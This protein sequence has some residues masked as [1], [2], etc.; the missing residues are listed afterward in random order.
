QKTSST[1][2]S[3]DQLESEF[4]AAFHNGDRLAA[5]K[6]MGE[7]REAIREKYLPQRLAMSFKGADADKSADV[8][9]A[10]KYSGDIEL[11]VRKDGFVNDIA[12]IYASMDEARFAKVGSAQNAIRDGYSYCKA[13]NYTDCLSSFERARDQFK[14]AGDEPEAK[15]AEYFVGYAQANTENHAA[16]L[17]TITGVAD[18]ARSHGYRWLEMTATHWVGGCL[19]ALKKHTEALAT[20]ERALAMAREANDPHA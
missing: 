1:D 13:N 5:E 11:S 9:N 10:L 2:R 12:G 15:L 6:L 7:S 8:L 14:M 17:T 4:L 19:V 20:Y 16:A 18:Y 3:A